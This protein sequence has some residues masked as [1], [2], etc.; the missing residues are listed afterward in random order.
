MKRTLK[1]LRK[2]EIETAEEDDAA[3]YSK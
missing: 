3:S 1:H 2:R